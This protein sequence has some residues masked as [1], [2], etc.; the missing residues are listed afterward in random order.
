MTVINDE[1]LLYSADELQFRQQVRNFIETEITPITDKITN[2]T[3]DYR[4]LF[5]KFVEC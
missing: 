3:I 2:Q 5:K 1:E 4:I